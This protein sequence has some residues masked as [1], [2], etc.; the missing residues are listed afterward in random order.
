MRGQTDLLPHAQAFSDYI[1]RNPNIK[2]ILLS[3]SVFACF[4][5]LVNS[6]VLGKKRHSGKI[7]FVE[8]RA[9]RDLLI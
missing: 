6:Q 9:A 8:T 7:T 5:E 1:D 2:S 3:D 4:A